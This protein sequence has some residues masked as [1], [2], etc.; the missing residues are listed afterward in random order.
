MEIDVS[1]ELMHY[2]SFTEGKNSERKGGYPVKK[3]TR[4]FLLHVLESIEVIETYAGYEQG[5]IHGRLENAGC[6]A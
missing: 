2:S 5:G 4:T 3:D 6:C 1:T